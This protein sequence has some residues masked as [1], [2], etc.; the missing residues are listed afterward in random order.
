MHSIV[1]YN[2]QLKY[3]NSNSLGYFHEVHISYVQDTVFV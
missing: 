2:L 3:Y 1:T